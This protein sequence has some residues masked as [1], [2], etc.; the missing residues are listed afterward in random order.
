MKTAT[1]FQAPSPPLTTLYHPD[2]KTPY[3]YWNIIYRP[4]GSINASAKDMAAYVRFYLNRGTVDGMQVMP[5]SSI[6]RMES[7]DAH[8]GGE[9][10][11][12]N[13]LWHEQ[14]LEHPRRLRV[15]RT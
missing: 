4:A 10:R 12:E 1:Y 6:D 8:L 9:R 11:I 5:A 15:P 13:R 2:G 3:P 7:P 14:L